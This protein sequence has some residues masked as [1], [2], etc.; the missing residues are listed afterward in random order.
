VPLKP[1]SQLGCLLCGAWPAVADVFIPKDRHLAL[2]PPDKLR[3]VAY[4][5][6]ADCRQLPDVL[7]RVEK[8][9][10]AGAAELFGQPDLN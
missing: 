3:G 4:A 5:L 1:R 6:C 10:T 7:A 9:A 8:A 2:A